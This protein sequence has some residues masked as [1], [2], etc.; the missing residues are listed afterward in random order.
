M[1]DKEIIT[2]VKKQLDKLGL[3]YD[4]RKEFPF[5]VE[6][7]VTIDI[8]G[9]SKNVHDVSFWTEFDEEFAFFHNL[10]SAE[11]DAQTFKV[12]RVNTHHN[13]LYLDE[14]GKVIN[15]N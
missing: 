6:R 5:N 12:L 1:T 3:G 2:I 13:S 7:D 15:D 10:F 11:V 14:N 8:K 9:V 4:T